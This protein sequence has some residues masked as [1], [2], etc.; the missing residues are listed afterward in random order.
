MKFTLLPSKHP[1]YALLLA[2]ASMGLSPLAAGVTA[3][4]DTAKKNFVG[5]YASNW[6]GDGSGNDNYSITSGTGATP[7]AN[8]DGFPDSDND[9]YRDPGTT[10]H[11]PFGDQFYYLQGT[12][13]APGPLAR[14]ED[15]VG[16]VNAPF[17][18]SGNRMV[19]QPVAPNGTLADDAHNFWDD[20]N[21]GS[22]GYQINLGRNTTLDNLVNGFYV[23]SN[24]TAGSLDGGTSAANFNALLSYDHSK[25]GSSAN[26]RFGEGFKFG[27]SQLGVHFTPYGVVDARWDTSLVA[28]TNYTVRFE[29]KDNGSGQTDIEAFLDGNSLGVQTYDNINPVVTFDTLSDAQHSGNH[30]NDWYIGSG[31]TGQYF[32][33]E[34]SYVEVGDFVPEPASTLLFGLA[35]LGLFLRRRR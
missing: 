18:P 2:S 23:E 33:G 4:W 35:S 25:G 3:R 7:D 20:G 9:G 15:A 10:D 26:D 13:S 32:D 8:G 17:R 31:G 5:P 28:G 24:F 30:L 29:L 12:G 34:I 19:V 1:L 21:G 11:G 6:D 22:E 16:T 14:L 27:V